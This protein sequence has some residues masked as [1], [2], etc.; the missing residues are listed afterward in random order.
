M[1]NEIE[2]IR[3]T[4]STNTA[5]GLCL[6]LDSFTEERGARLS[7][8]DVYRLAV[9]MTDGKSNHVSERCNY[10]STIEVAQKVH[11]YSHPILVFAIGVTDNV[12][13]DELKAIATRE[14]YITYLSMFDES[15]FRETSDEQ[16]YE[17]CV[18]SKWSVNTHLK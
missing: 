1:L 13:D 8:G 18:K 11:N 12:N 4:R 14:E 6:L 17:L 3:Y 16:T 9:V 15:L 2:D 5:D 7:A 10:S